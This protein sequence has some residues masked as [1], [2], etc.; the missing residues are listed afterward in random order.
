MF[1]LME[2]DVPRDAVAAPQ[3]RHDLR[4]A[5][6]EAGPLEK[7]RSSSWS[8]GW[9]YVLALPCTAL[10]WGMVHFDYY[11]AR[12][13]VRPSL[14]LH[15]SLRPF[16][17]LGLI[18]GASATCCV[19]FNLLYLLRRSHFG[20]RLGGS[21]GRWLSYHMTMGFTALVLATLHAGFTWKRSSGGHAL[22]AMGI[23]VCSGACGRFLFPA[24]SKTKYGGWLVGWRFFHRW[25]A[26]TMV[27][28]L[29]LH[30][31]TSLRYA[32]WS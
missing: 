31:V 3:T 27:L 14:A 19:A 6:L 20:R 24:L 26:F 16:G 29:A 15:E 4:S 21:L 8:I 32:R 30:V 12:I 28:L 2:S 18:C 10:L 13:G 11:S 22:L 17:H 23:L 25:T 7:V 9:L 5:Q 1:V